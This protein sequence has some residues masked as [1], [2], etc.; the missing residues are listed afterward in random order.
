VSEYERGSK[1]EDF[2]VYDSNDEVRG[3]G[4]KSSKCVEEYKEEKSVVSNSRPMNI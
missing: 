2:D 3:S 1:E 4:S